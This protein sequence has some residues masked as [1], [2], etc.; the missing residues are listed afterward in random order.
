MSFKPGP[1]GES[2]A[3]LKMEACAKE[4]YAWM[5]CNRLNLNRDKTEF[6]VINAKHRACPSICNIKIASV[7]VVPTE[8]GRNIGVMFNDIMNHEHQVPNI[9][10]VAFFH[11]CNLSK[12]RKCLTQKDIEMLVH[13]FV[14]SKLHNCNS[15]LAELP[16]YLLDKVQRVQN[17]AA[18]LISHTR[19]YDRIMPVHRELH[20]LPVKQR[21]IFKI[22]LFSY[23]A[24]KAL[25]PQY[26]SDF[27][28]QYKP[29]RAL[30]SS[31]KKLLQVPHFKLKSYGGRSF[32]GTSFQTPYGKH[33][34][35][36]H[37]SPTLRRIC[38]IKL[39]INH[40]FFV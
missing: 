19:K 23:K 3:M 38:L 10:K 35:L 12:I 21:I 39:L 31:D 1:D 4:I 40:S 33:H 27:L 37:L 7:R 18:H 9:C 28:V 15:L 16:Q 2:A 24:L 22:L 11:M 26:I 34:R 5:A 6:L 32:S 14:T 36:R 25:A 29:P 20:W 13:A 30:R 17:A 8:S